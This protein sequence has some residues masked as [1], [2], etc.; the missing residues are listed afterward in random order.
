MEADRWLRPQ[1]RLMV[2]TVGITVGGVWLFLGASTACAAVWWPEHHI[3]DNTAIE[4]SRGTF[5]LSSM[6]SLPWLVIWLWFHRVAWLVSPDG[7][8]VYRRG[9]LLRSYAWS[10]IDS[11]HVWSNYAV[12]RAPRCRFGDEIFWLST[13][14][15]SWLRG[16]V[17]HPESSKRLA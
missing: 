3:L 10:D 1:T 8:A 15:A 6:F 4:W 7:I 11:L 9:K 12:V 16:R 2:I 17:A 13:V 14:D 5:V